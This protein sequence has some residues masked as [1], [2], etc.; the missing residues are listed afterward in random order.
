[1]LSGSAVSS[2]STWSTF[3]VSCHYQGLQLVQLRLLIDCRTQRSLRHESVVNCCPNHTLSSTKI[4]TNFHEIF[5]KIKTF[6]NATGLALLVVIRANE[7]KKKKFLKFSVYFL[8]GNNSMHVRKLTFP[9][10]SAKQVSRKELWSQL[11]QLSDSPRPRA[12]SPR[13]GQARAPWK[14]TFW[15]RGINRK[16][17]GIS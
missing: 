4:P 12:R 8:V 14:L 1:M 15:G 10:S 11:Q 13:A 6:I 3:I 7:K 9:G 2:R 17:F 16:K 5:K